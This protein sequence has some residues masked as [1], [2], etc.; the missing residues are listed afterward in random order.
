MYNWQTSL[1]KYLKGSTLADLPNYDKSVINN[2]PKIYHTDWLDFGISENTLDK[3]NIRYYE[4]QSQ[5][6]I[7]VYSHNGNLIGIRVRNM[8]PNNIKYIPLS[9]LNG[10]MYNFPSNAI[11]YGECFNEAEIKRTKIVN[12]VEAEKSV[13]K[14]DTW[15]DNKSVTL[16]LL[17]SAL[18]K[19]RLDYLISLGVEEVNL[20]LDSDFEVTLD[21]NGEPIINQKQFELFQDKV[22]KLY[23]FMSPYFNKIYIVY[24][25]LGYT[26][27]YKANPFDFDIDR[28]NKLC[29]SKELIE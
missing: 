13:L 4:Y 24:N 7:P 20:M 8:N 27:M 18:G 15:F 22:Y 10:T 25:N 23:D 17:G 19:Q 5:I 26:D 2:Y 9:T 21:E 14:S 16:G 12:I 6:V 29:K 11:F 1:N 28:Y 3:Y